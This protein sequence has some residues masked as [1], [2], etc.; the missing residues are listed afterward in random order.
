MKLVINDNKVTV[1]E[2]LGDVIVKFKNPI[3]L[4]KATNAEKSFVVK[5]EEVK[6][7]TATPTCSCTLA[8]KDKNTITVTYTPPGLTESRKKV[9][10]TG[11]TEEGKQVFKTLII[12]AK[13]A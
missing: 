11:L 5:V 7:F 12:E 13:G 3:P 2:E 4:K 6:D 1:R 9:R 8:M 10:F